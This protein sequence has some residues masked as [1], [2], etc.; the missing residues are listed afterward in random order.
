[1]YKIQRSVR[2]NYNVIAVNYMQ[3]SVNQVTSDLLVA[4]FRAGGVWKSVSTDC[5][6]QSVMMAGEARMPLLSASS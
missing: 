5:G 2:Y 3:L 4:V 6:A 1:M